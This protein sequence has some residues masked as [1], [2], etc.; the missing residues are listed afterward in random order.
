MKLVSFHASF[1]EISLPE[2]Y[3]L[4]STYRK[5][6]YLNPNNVKNFLWYFDFPQFL[7]SASS[8]HPTLQLWLPHRFT[9]LPTSATRACLPAYPSLLLCPLHIT[10]VWVQCFFLALLPFQVQ[11]CTPVCFFPPVFLCKPVTHVCWLSFLRLL[12]CFFM[13][14][15][16]ASSTH[17]FPDQFEVEIICKE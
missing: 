4:L 13:Y 3:F 1:M 10:E 5:I 6:I 2:I 11:L 16:L 17:C 15:C 14:Y 9:H 12:S 8:S 7:I